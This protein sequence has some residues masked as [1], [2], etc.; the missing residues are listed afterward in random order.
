MTYTCSP[1]IQETGTAAQQ[2]GS[3]SHTAFKQQKE[4]QQ[5]DKQDA[6]K[7]TNYL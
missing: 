2:Y 7:E 1:S 5:E 6:I 3:Q 4:Q